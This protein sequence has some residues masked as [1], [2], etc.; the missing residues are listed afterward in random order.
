[1]LAKIARPSSTAATIDREVV[2][3]EDHVGGL[4]G[5][6][7]A[8]DAH[9]H[10]DVGGLERGRV[11]DAVAGHRDDRA[12]AL[13]RLDD[14]QLVL[15]IDARV[16]RDRRHASAA[17]S[18]S[19]MA[20]SSA[21]VTARAVA[22]DAEFPGDHRRG[23]RMIAGDHDRADAGA[24]CA[25]ATASFASSRGG[26][27]IP[28]RPANTRS[29]STRSSGSP[30]SGASAGERADGDAERAQR[31]AASASLICEDLRAGA[32]RSAAGGRRR[33]APACSAR[34]GHPAR[35]W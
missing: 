13:E 20:R 14:P 25:R 18:S 27:I 29:C 17:S 4:L 19:D 15:G 2:V 23:A 16:D 32:R 21:P 30:S 5:H 11:V 22:A 26:S 9:R 33:P 35:P 1:M 7:G 28:I 34:A 10:A 12:V 31:L 6:V 24:P 3:G 8:G